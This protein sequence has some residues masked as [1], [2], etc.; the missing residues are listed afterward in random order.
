MTEKKF[1]GT[2]RRARRIA[3]RLVSVALVVLALSCAAAAQSGRRN[4]QEP[5]R[6]EP[7]QPAPVIT[8]KIDT[9]GEGG[10]R[11]R[12]LPSVPLVVAGRIGP[13][14]TKAVAEVIYNSFA[15]HLG[16]SMK[17]ASIGLARRDEAVKR[18][19]E[20][21]WPFVAYIEF[22]FESFRDG[23]VVFSSPDIL[24]KYAVVDV[25]TGNT[26][27]KGTVYFR[28]MHGGRPGSGEGAIKITPESAGQ[29]AADQVLD[30]FALSP[31]RQ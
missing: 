21:A 5:A 16:A 25:Q 9:E 11:A 1:D 4:R 2:R 20:E 8:P 26:K 14:V 24:V 3:A 10:R 27:A 19:R 13:K 12:N 23:A 7:P 15:I 28:P 22:E 17:V 29:E 30:W 31:S 18:A 6:N